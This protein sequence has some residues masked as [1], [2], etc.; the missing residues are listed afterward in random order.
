MEE[1]KNKPKLTISDYE[2][3]GKTEYTYEIRGYNIYFSKVG[4]NTYDEANKEGEKKL[5][6]YVLQRMWV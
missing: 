1:K 2:F 6:E 4:F 5:A 3:E